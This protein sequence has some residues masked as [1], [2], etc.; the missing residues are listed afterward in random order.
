MLRLRAAIVLLAAPLFAACGSGQHLQPRF[1]VN[2]LRVVSVADGRR[3][4][5]SAP[6]GVERSIGEQ[7]TN[8]ARS[9]AGGA[10]V[11]R[12]GLHDAAM[13]RSCSRGVR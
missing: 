4:S 13:S 12:A 2:D 3:D 1:S 9:S 6:A 5:S 7:G 8:A 11:G 10:S